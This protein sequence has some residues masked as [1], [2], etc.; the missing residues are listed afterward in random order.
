MHRGPA[1]NRRGFSAR[2]W[3]H[4]EEFEWMNEARLEEF[5]EQLE[6]LRTKVEAL[7]ALELINCAKAQVRLRIAGAR[8]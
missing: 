3:I 1:V 4:S 8:W 7:T 2:E 5:F 6:D